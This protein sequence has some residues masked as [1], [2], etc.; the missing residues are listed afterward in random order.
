M[1]NPA[2]YPGS[3]TLAPKGTTTTMI[4]SVC[5]RFFFSITSFGKS[6]Y[7]CGVFLQGQRGSTSHGDLAEELLYLV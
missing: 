4:L 7:L 5:G 2:A 1:I 3:T 6:R